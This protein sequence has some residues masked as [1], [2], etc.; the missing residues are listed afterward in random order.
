MFAC[1]SDSDDDVDDN[2]LDVSN[3]HTTW[4]GLYKAAKACQEERGS[5]QVALGRGRRESEP[6]FEASLTCSEYKE[7][8]WTN[9]FVKLKSHGY[10]CFFQ[11]GHNQGNIGWL[12]MLAIIYL[13]ATIKSR[14]IGT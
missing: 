5:Q 2:M 10:C 14:R 4:Q 11:E 3:P 1:I 8:R 13:M 9:R 6:S 7:S 12:M